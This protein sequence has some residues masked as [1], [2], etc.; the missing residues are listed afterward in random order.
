MQA[1]F[2]GLPRR[3]GLGPMLW[4]FM[5]MLHLILYLFRRDV[6]KDKRT[7]EDLLRRV[8]HGGASA[9]HSLWIIKRDALIVLGEAHL[10]SD[11]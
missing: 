1:V 6:L 3:P 11:R 10:E 4:R 8:M 2:P 5:G 7:K 9:K